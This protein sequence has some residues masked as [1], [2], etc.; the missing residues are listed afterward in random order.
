MTLTSSPFD[1]GKLRLNRPLMDNHHRSV[2][3]LQKQGFVVV[4]D[5]IPHICARGRAVPARIMTLTR[6][7]WDISRLNS[8]EEI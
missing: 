4:G 5:H 1:D 8:A 2:R 6:S 7:L 3:G